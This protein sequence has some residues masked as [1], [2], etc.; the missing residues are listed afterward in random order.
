MTKRKKLQIRPISGLLRNWLTCVMP[1]KLPVPLI[2]AALFAVWLAA[3][4]RGNSPEAAGEEKLRIAAASSLS[5]VLDSVAVEFE[6]ETGISCQIQYG[7]TGT[8]ISQMANGMEV[9]VFLSVGQ[10]FLEQMANAGLHAHSS[11]PLHAFDL[12]LMLSPNVEGEDA[13]LEALGNAHSVAVPN[14]VSAPLGNHFM[15]LL[16]NEHPL[17]ARLVIDKMVRT[18]TASQVANLVETGHADVGVVGPC[19]VWS[20]DKRSDYRFL[21]LYTNGMPIYV[22][23]LVMKEEDRARRFGE[24]MKGQKA[25]AW[26]RK[27]HYLV[28][29]A[30]P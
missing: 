22:N 18:E 2:L 25:N 4:G 5:P 27:A 16:A 17:M 3:C 8:L 6:K 13:W 20:F 28:K 23:V 29:E 15:K 10:E 26:F 7:A 30:Q 21:P 1:R 11:S 12:F 9:D 19:T 24:F 14:P